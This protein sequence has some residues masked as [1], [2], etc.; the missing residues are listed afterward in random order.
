M[1]QVHMNEHFIYLL[2]NF[3]YLFILAA[4]DLR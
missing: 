1:V 3:I 4:L 2:L